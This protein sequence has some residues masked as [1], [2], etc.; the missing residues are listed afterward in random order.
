MNYDQRINFLKDW[1][2]S[3]I[4]T[5]FNMPRDL[6]QKVVAMDIIEAVNR[7]IHSGADQQRMSHL[8]AS[9]T[10]EVTQSAKSRTLPTAKEFVDACSIASNS[11]REPVVGTSK[12]DDDPHA[13]TAKR[14]RSGEAISESYLR[15]VMRLELQSRH[16]ITDEQL[17]P[18]EIFLEKAAY[19]Q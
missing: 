5:R 14:V 17:K 1:F 2:K 11:Y 12:R 3:D 16:G 18:Y 9:I 13:I 6:D 10:K 19:K 4:I 8:V 7:N 15:G